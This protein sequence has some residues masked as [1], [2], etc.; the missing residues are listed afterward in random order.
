MFRRHALVLLLLAL[1]ATAEAVVQAH[2]RVESV[3]SGCLVNDEDPFPLGDPE[4]YFRMAV[5]DGAAT[6]IL[7]ACANGCTDNGSPS[8]LDGRTLDFCTYDTGCGSFNFADQEITKVLPDGAGAYFYFGLFDADDLDEDDSLGDHWL[9]ADGFRSATASNTNSSPY[10]PAHS[11]ATVCGDPVEGIGST[12]NYQV[13]YRIW[14]EDTDGPPAP[15]GV[16]HRDNG[17]VT[18][19]NDDSRLDF[20]W[21]AAVDPH[22]GTS[23][24]RFSLY[25]ETVGGFVFDY[26]V[27]PVDRTLSLCP[28]GCDRTYTPVVNHTYWFRVHALNGDYPT[29]T[30]STGVSTITQTPSVWI[31]VNNIVVGVDGAPAGL[32]LSRPV[33]NPSSGETAVNYE[34]AAAGPVRLEVL[35]LQGRRVRSLVD[36]IGEAGPH[37]LDW[38]G[39]DESGR[40]VD[41][42][43]F[44]LRLSAGSERRSQRLVI[45]R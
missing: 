21:N 9:L 19:T 6:G 24:Y 15:D 27:A 7:I 16:V 30:T 13:T 25:D 2:F 14:F 34:L 33:P 44:W 22:S 1:P 17:V 10:Y 29:L 31:V 8:I 4:R 23:E 5:F 35:D 45:A 11:L 43:V 28:V 38:D 12:S 37:R 20:E 40:P 36:G 42:G 39:R 3:N 18:N 32:N 26:Q 41:S